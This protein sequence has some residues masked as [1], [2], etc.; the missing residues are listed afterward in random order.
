MHTRKKVFILVAY[1]IVF[2]LFLYYR[3]NAKKIEQDYFRQK[4][5]FKKNTSD[6]LGKYINFFY[7]SGIVYD[8]DVDFYFKSD[9]VKKNGF[10]NGSFDA[11]TDHWATSGAN[12]KLSW[13]SKNELWLYRES[14]VSAPYC[15]KV[16][17]R[18]YPCRVFY[19][20]DPDEKLINSPTPPI[21]NQKSQ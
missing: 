8:P 17:A 3:I 10:I 18:E 15:L 2:S 5:F 16:I 14:F 19:T 12:E 11:N 13:S 7:K 6:N 21:I 4:Y 9:Y 1:L 20:K